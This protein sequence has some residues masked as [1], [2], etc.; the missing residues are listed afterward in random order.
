M[1]AATGMSQSA[2]SRI[3]RASDLKPH[4]LETWKLSTDP[5]FIDKVR[6]AGDCIWTRRRTAVPGGLQLHLVCDNCATHKTPAIQDW[7]ARNPRFPPAL[8][9]DQLV[10]DESPPMARWNSR[11]SPLLYEARARYLV[12]QGEGRFTDPEPP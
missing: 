12:P 1:A 8:H 3:W 10:M 9:P 6:D 7:L 11:S 2:I 4:H 5:Q